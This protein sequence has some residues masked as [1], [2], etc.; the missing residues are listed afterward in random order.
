MLSQP[1]STQHETLFCSCC[2]VERAATAD[3]T[4]LC[5]MYMY[6]AHCGCCQRETKHNPNLCFNNAYTKPILGGNQGVDGIV[7]MVAN[8]YCCKLYIKYIDAFDSI[9][10]YHVILKVLQL[11]GLN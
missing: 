9:H 5:T 6:K 8:I 11:K 7:N 4:S 1:N 2:A 3:I 10:H